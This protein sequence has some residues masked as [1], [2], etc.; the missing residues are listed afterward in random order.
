MAEAEAA[1]AHATAD[2][3]Q[4]P[5]FEIL[6]PTPSTAAMAFLGGYFFAVY[7]VLRSYF[8][9]DLRP[10]LYNQITARLVTVVILAYLLTVVWA[11]ASEGERGTR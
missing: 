5:Y 8:S 11:P 3:L 6:V 2:S 10:K 9:G 1:E 4:R 7:L